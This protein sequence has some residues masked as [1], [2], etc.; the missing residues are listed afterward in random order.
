VTKRLLIIDNLNLFLRSYIVD[1][2]LST[3]GQPIGGL[4][5]ALKALQKICREVKPDRIA[6]CWD[7]Q[8]GSTKRRLMHK[9]YKEG[10]KTLRLN[11]DVK[12][13]TEDQELQNKIWQQTRLAEYYNEMPIMQF[14]FK[15]IEADDVISY[16]CNL[17]EY[18]DYQKVI[19]S[20]DKDFYQLLNDSTILYRPTQKQ[21]INKKQ[22]IDEY[23][24]HPNN[25]ALARA[26]AGDRS[27]NLKGVEGVG[28]KTAAKRFPM[29]LKEQGATVDEVVD[30]ARTS[31]EE[32]KLKIYEKVA[33]NYDLILK[34]YQIMQLYT[35][36]LSIEAKKTIRETCREPDLGVNKTELMKMMLQDGFGEINF[37]ELFQNLKRIAVNR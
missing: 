23:G 9:G 32:K 17:E 6:V 34:N 25:F 14:M 5:G 12:I 27:D 26:M 37:S 31:L 15:A 28:L 11:R 10:R 1:P 13:L 24:I 30:Y 21:I 20:S 29:L 22:L 36:V 35:P 18:K 16:I 4:K 2:S 19:V 8:G 33:E 7:G 3:N